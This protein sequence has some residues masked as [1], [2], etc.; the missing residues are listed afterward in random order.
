MRAER[1]VDSG[2]TEHLDNSGIE[3]RR[4]ALTVDGIIQIEGKIV[5]VR[6]GRPPFEGQL[7]LPGGFVEYGERVEDAARREVKEETGLSTQ[8]IRL[9]GVYSEPGR[10][11][12]GHTVSVAYV[13]R[14]LD[15]NAK[16]GSDAA[17]VELIELDSV[18]KLAFDHSRIV[19]DYLESEASLRPNKGK[20]HN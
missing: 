16:A 12:R 15:M 1:A 2:K 10:D 7:A 11:P 9:L 13:M 14:A 4:S 17:A 8:I 20:M 19:S 18:P 3:Y 5:L 6:R